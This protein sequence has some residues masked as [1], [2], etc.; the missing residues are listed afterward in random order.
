MPQDE[1]YNTKK[2]LRRKIQQYQE[3]QTTMYY[4]NKYLKIEFPKNFT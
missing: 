4:P 1:A 3:L 2:G